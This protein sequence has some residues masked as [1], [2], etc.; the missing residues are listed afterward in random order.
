MLLIVIITSS[1][2]RN[3]LV[4]RVLL[5]V[6]RINITPLGII[7]IGY[8]NFVSE[9]FQEG[10]VP[11]QIRIQGTRGRLGVFWRQGKLHF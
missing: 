5:I 1:Q 11:A 4:L 9:K 2:L 8:A 6:S 7:P 3:I 10:G